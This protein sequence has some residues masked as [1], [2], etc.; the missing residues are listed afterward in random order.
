M[1]PT[2]PMKCLLR[3]L[4]GLPEDILG[5]WRDILISPT[6]SP[7]G[8]ICPWSWHDVHVVKRDRG[9]CCYLPLIFLTHILIM[10]IV[11]TTSASLS[12]P[13]NPGS[14]YPGLPQ[15]MPHVPPNPTSC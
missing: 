14:Y 2:V 3:V 11:A 13:P 6:G 15:I 4:N 1:P 5:I 9:I 7:T 12:F 10:P 8:V